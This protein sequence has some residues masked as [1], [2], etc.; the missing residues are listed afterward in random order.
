MLYDEICLFYKVY[1]GNC[2][3]K[4]TSSAV[5]YMYAPVLRK[6]VIVMVNLLFVLP[7]FNFL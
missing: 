2:H 1:A 3:L 6:T 7:E 4:S 5:N